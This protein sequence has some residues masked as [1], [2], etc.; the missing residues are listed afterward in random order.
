MD[1]D[2]YNRTWITIVSD[3][4]HA[5]IAWKSALAILV[6]GACDARGCRIHDFD[7][8]RA[9]GLIPA[10]IRYRASA[11]DLIVLRELAGGNHISALDVR[12]VA[13]W[14]HGRCHNV[15][16]SGIIALTNSVTG[17]IDSG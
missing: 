11:I 17:A 5:E 1:L 7:D 12:R 4:G 13:A 16:T 9:T 2:G 15:S 3:R 8:E 14:V 6:G 10:V